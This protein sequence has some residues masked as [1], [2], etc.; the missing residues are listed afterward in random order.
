[1]N[2]Y[3]IKSEKSYVLPQA[4]YRQALY[5]VKD[6]DRLRRKL[7]FL[8]KTKNKVS[9]TDPSYLMGG[10][11]LITDLTGNIA[12]EITDTEA[13]IN[14]IESAFDKI[15]DKYRDGI[16]E[17][18]VYDVPYDSNVHCMNTWKKYQQMLIYY[19][20]ENLRIL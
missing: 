19:V 9:I 1:M 10:G 16:E 20:A 6:L 12:T 2:D 13:R 4:V 7:S 18:L 5:A 3:Q 17:K 8:I 14:A 11:G 15:P